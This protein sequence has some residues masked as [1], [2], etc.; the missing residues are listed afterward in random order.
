LL[1]HREALGPGRRR[2]FSAALALVA[3]ASVALA[4]VALASVALASVALARAKDDITGRV[5][6]NGRRIQGL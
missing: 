1:L 3:L 6:H 4:S 2:T 5:L